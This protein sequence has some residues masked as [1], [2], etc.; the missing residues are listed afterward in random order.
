MN[1]KLSRTIRTLISLALA[2]TLVVASVLPATAYTEVNVKHVRLVALDGIR[3]G[4]PIR[5][6]ATLTDAQG[7]PVAGA[8]VFF[9]FKKKNAGDMLAPTFGFSNAQ[10]KVQTTLTLSPSRGVRQIVA[11]VAA[12]GTASDQFTISARAWPGCG[13]ASGGGGIVLPPTGT[14]EIAPILP[15]EALPVGVLVGIASI[16]L[17]AFIYAMRRTRDSRLSRPR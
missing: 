10:G 1:T 15:A 14:A 13:S 2:G 4:S 5:L 12:P 17:L 8:L 6:E 9:T 11:T 16:A 7:R 3:C